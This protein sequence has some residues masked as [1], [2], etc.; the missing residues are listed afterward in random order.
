MAEARKRLFHSRNPYDLEGTEQLFW[1]AMAENC[2]FQQE[3]CTEYRAILEGFGFHPQE[4]LLEDG[5]G[6]LPFLPTL[7]FKSH[8]LFSMP[9]GRLPIKATSSG[10]KGKMSRMGFD[11]K[12][13]LCGL[14]MVLRL[15][16][17]HHLF[18][19]T[20]AHYVVLGYQRH[21]GNQMAVRK[22]AFGTTLFAPALNREYALKYGKD[23]YYVDLE[24][25]TKA[26]LR[27]EHSRFPTRVIGFPSYTWFLL[28]HLD[29]QG[30]RLH[31]KPGSKIMLGGGW[32]QFYTQQ[33]EKPVLYG[34]AKKVLGIGEGDIAEFFGAVEHPIMYCDCENH[35]FHV[36]V[37]SRVIIR[38]I[39]TLKPLPHGQPGLVNLLTP[40]VHSMPILS[41]M[42]DDL[43]VLHDGAECGCGIASPWLE[44]L[45]RV[46]V[47]DIKTCAA[48]AADI[49]KNSP[50][51]VGKGGVL[52]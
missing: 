43:G 13:L 33:V 30:I 3:H 24:G 52:L 8:E 26:L 34:L 36:P 47:Q 4:L 2:A 7:F 18:S 49:L 25:L 19:M 21:K 20:P 29:E 10:T 9:P 51:A 48:G 15:G 38:D 22:T 44:I 31:L 5:P 32:K 23:G 1:Q 14:H 12:G 35:H 16:R 6:R 42:T 37:Y 45:G 11:A 28:R 40:M 41:V 46:G 17:V 50:A 27:F 39:H